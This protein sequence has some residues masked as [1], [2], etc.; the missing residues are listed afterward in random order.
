[1]KVQQPKEKEEETPNENLK[2]TKVTYSNPPITTE[3]NNVLRHF[4]IN[5]GYKSPIRQEISSN[6]AV[7]IS[8]LGNIITVPNFNYNYVSK[9]KRTAK[10]YKDLLRS[11]RFDV[12][13]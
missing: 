3:H 5:R 13:E 10:Y 4:K 11:D 8:E 9:V 7:M 2:I 1:M 6:S 12:A